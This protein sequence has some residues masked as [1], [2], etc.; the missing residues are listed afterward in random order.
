MDNFSLEKFFNEPVKNPFSYNVSIC[1]KK[2]MN[3]LFAE[4]KNIFLTGLL[5]KTE[6]KYIETDL[7]TSISLEK[8]NDKEIEKVKNYMLSI[9]IELVH[10]KYNL[11]DKD[12]YIRQL[13]Y[14]IQNIKNIKIKVTSDWVT[15]H[16]DKVSIGVEK[17]QVNELNAILIQYPESNYFLNLYKPVNIQ[18]FR[19][20]FVK[21]NEPD[22]INVIYFQP[23]KI[24]D[25]HYNHQYMDNFDKHVR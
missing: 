24:T 19:I 25:Y 2:N 11:D 7:G 12:Y 15:Q 17:E 21:Q 22:I 4:L 23:A 14:K 13:L 5:Y 6:N 3:E 8:V 1:N 20:Q 18:D 9:G 10:K 16:I